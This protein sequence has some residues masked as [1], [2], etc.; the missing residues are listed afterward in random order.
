MAM[1]I[2]AGLFL[3][4]LF[5]CSGENNAPIV[6]RQKVYTPSYTN[7]AELW[8]GNGGIVLTETCHA[9]ER[10]ILYGRMADVGMKTTNVSEEIWNKY[11]VG[12]VF[13]EV[14]PSVRLEAPA[15]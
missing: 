3:L 7:W 5:G 9:E 2:M 14:Y 11:K 8:Q 12:D 4:A 15:P 1:K 10:L 13:G 6:V